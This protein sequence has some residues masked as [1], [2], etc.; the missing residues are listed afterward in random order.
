MRK[1]TGEMLRAVTL[2]LAGCCPTAALAEKCTSRPH[3]LG[4]NFIEEW[5]WV[6]GR[7]TH[8]ATWNPNAPSPY[9]CLAPDGTQI[10]GPQ[11]AVDCAHAVA[12]MPRPPETP[13]P[14]GPAIAPTPAPQQQAAP[15]PKSAPALRTFAGNLIEEDAAV[16]DDFNTATIDAL[17]AIVRTNGYPCGSV[18][19]AR[20]YLIARGFRLTCDHFSYVY[21][22]EPD[23]HGSMQLQNPLF[24]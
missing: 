10:Y 11:N 16:P 3:S 13:R 20:S 7:C 23:G 18:S 1:K 2:L 21:D 14:T 19:G 6:N 4:P 24:R 12:T 17:V 15:K 5:R 9:T 22:F 8:I